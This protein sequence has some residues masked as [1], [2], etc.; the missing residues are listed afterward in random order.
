[1]D[2]IY[3]QQSRKERKEEEDKREEEEEEDEEHEEHEEDE[4]GEEEEEKEEEDEDEERST[5]GF[6]L[7]LTLCVGQCGGVGFID[8][9]RCFF[10]S[11]GVACAD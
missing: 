6:F 2:K 7:K 8:L 1:M 9:S 11:L 3:E 4:E 5:W 10:N